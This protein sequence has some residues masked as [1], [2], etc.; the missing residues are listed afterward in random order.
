MP[1]LLSVMRN[2][3]DA[4]ELCQ[5]KLGIDR[6][7][8]P[9]L[10]AVAEQLGIT[11]EDMDMHRALDDSLITARC[12]QKVWDRELFDRIC[13][14]ADDEFIRRLLFKP[15]F[16]CD[17]RNPAIKPE[18]LETVCQQCGT[19]MTAEGKPWPRG[20]QV[21]IKYYCPQCDK[22]IIGRH[23]FRM[24]FDGLE[25]KLSWREIP[26][27]EEETAEETAAEAAEDNSAGGEE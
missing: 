13:R 17:T 22:S 16:I 26:P 8:Q 18:M 2:Y 21:N 10:S 3:C 25:H 15:Y 9:G 4:Q 7:K 11:C 12:V 5:H 6:A 23:Q 24:R 14:P 20:R 19:P 1:S 27:P